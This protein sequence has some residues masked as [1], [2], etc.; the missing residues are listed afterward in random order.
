MIQNLSFSPIRST[1]PANSKFL[2]TPQTGQGNDFRDVL[3]SNKTNN[4]YTALTSGSQ[5]DK[6]I[7]AIHQA[8]I[9]TPNA[10]KPAAVQA[11]EPFSIRNHYTMPPEEVKPLLEK[12]ED[13]IRNT[14]FS[15]KTN[16]EIYGFIENKYKEVFGD[17]FM[18]GHHLLMVVPGSNMWNNPDRPMSNY[19]YIDIGFSF[20]GLV[21][22]EVG[23]MEM[24]QI[25]RTRLYGDKSDGEVIDAIIAKYP[26]AKTN[27]DLALIE[28]ELQSVGISFHSV[29]RLV[30]ALIIKPDEMPWDDNYPSWAEF[31]DR[32]NKIMNARAN[33]QQLAYMHNGDIK[34]ARTNP[35]VLQSVMQTVNILVKLGAELGP[36]GYFLNPDK[37]LFVSLDV[38]LGAGDS[39]ELFDEFLKD[40]EQHEKNLQESR[41]QLEKNLNTKEAVGVYESASD[42]YHNSSKAES[43][44]VTL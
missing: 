33:V 2:P 27:R 25:N 19:E 12:L 17:D 16:A 6:L 39:D 7:D 11:R 43:T 35:L 15:G 10:F 44:D 28:A 42:N 22:N 21:S 26:Q 14:D 3:S 24:I 4:I 1:V 34:E 18:M 30:D 37:S 20:K 40:L 31:E 29:G 41:E 23:Y 13:E 5:R 32:W 8:R 38:E 9:F 36:D